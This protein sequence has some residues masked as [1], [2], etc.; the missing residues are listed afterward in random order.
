MSRERKQIEGGDSFSRGLMTARRSVAASIA[1]R[2]HG[3]TR[4]RF[5]VAFSVFVLHVAGFAAETT[6][7]GSLSA[8]FARA[9][10]TPDPRMLNW[11]L[12][13]PRPY[14]EMH[15]PLFARVL[16]LSARDTRV[17]L[18]GW[19]LLDARD[20]AVA[21]VRQAVSAATGIPSSHIMIQATHTHSGPKSEMGTERALRREEVTSRPVHDGPTY[22]EW[23][24]RLVETCIT[25]VQKADATKQPV[26]LG[27]GRA[28][29][30][31]WLFNR[32]PL[33]PDHTVQSTLV[34]RDPHVLGDGL[35]FGS[36]DPTM[37]VMTLRDAAG[38]NVCTLFHLPMHAVAV[39]SSYKGIS[40]DWPGRVTDLLRGKLGGEA[41]F[42]Q[43]CA[44]D[45][46]PARRGFEAVE[47]MSALIAD[48]AAAAARA[49]ATL[50]RTGPLR[51]S[52]HVVGL[53]A[54]EAAA[55]DLGRVTIDAEISVVSIGP[56][57]LVTLPGEPLQEIS[58]AILQRS[59]FPHT[60]VLGY[61]NGRG[62][63]YI[64]LP[65]GKSRGG[66]EMSEVGAGTDDAG[67]LLVDAAVEL[68]R[69]HAATSDSK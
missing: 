48:R 54:T 52:R 47:A 32:R 27:L 46:V 26:T 4:G 66:Y 19:D 64:G 36:V 56:V 17:V 30:G 61:A 18:L 69:Q 7:G 22:R 6:A 68:L 62:V 45:I 53:P 1:V 15:D 63:G 12:T 57:V 2:C 51:V 24:D 11:T 13:P 59:P 33:R 20:F 55:K 60:L 5:A 28:Y 44:G 3:A 58:T 25:L 34:P 67:G 29:A 8:G 43:G 42:L 39:Y 21:R 23:A 50:T 9:D 35:R 65:G 14:G 16:V 37:T 31:E 38:A 10:I 49:G 41:M 40:A